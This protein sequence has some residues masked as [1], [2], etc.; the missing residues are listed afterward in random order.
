M[1]VD[2]G[3]PSEVDIQADSISDNLKPFTGC[4]HAWTFRERPFPL[5]CDNE[6]RACQFQ[7]IPKK[8]NQNPSMTAYIIISDGS[9][10]SSFSKTVLGL[11]YRKPSMRQSKEMQS[12]QSW[13]GCLNGGLMRPGKH[14]DSC[15]YHCN[16][17][18]L[19]PVRHH[20]H[21]RFDII[22]ISSAPSSTP[23]VRHHRHFRFDIIIHTLLL[24]S[25]L[26]LVY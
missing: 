15:Y 13:L 18:S 7:G 3:T 11:A 21:F 9:N 19:L 20:R 10:S 5:R 2:A 1:A 12:H 22:V 25:S 6:G 17:T 23:A 14:D 26:V 4:L 8:R 16:R 24:H